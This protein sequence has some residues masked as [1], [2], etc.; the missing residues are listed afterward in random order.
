MQWNAF[1]SVAYI[2]NSNTQSGNTHVSQYQ[3]YLSLP[4]INLDTRRKFIYCCLFKTFPFF[5]YFPQTSFTH[6]TVSSLYFVRN[7][8]LKLSVFYSFISQSNLQISCRST[9][10]SLIMF[11]SKV[12]CCMQ[13][14]YYTVQYGGCCTQLQ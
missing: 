11:C 8:S 12:L 10:E 2:Y 6:I 4:V 1:I 14:M 13:A 7:T 3:K 5:S 9:E